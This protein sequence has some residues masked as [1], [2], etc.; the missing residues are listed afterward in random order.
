MCFSMRRI[1]LQTKAT[2]RTHTLCTKC[3]MTQ[4][5]RDS[6]RTTIQQPTGKAAKARSTVAKL[7]QWC[8][9]H[10]HSLRCRAQVLI[11]RTSA[12]CHSQSPSTANSLHLQ[13]LT[14]ALVSTQQHQTT[15]RKLLSY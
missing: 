11:H 5:Q 9:V 4:P 7:Q 6:L 12:I 13:V 14:T 10:G 15:T 3:F 2:T 8:S 1:H